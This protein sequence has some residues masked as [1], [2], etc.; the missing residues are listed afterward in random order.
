M[1]VEKYI[2][3]FERKQIQRRW[4]NYRLMAIGSAIIGLLFCIA[5]PL[6]VKVVTR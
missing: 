2:Q 5:I 6:L 3:E 4:D 1:N